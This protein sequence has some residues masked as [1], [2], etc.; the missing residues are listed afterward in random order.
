MSILTIVSLVKPVKDNL[1][2]P[3]SPSSCTRVWSD[4]PN[5]GKCA[6]ISSGYSGE[7]CLDGFKVS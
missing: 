1:L 7:T 3:R 5:A 4:G 2:L 6:D